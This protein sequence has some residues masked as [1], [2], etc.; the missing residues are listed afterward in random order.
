MELLD[1]YGTKVRELSASLG[2]WP[3]L[4]DIDINN[5][6]IDTL[7]GS[8]GECW[9]LERIEYRTLRAIPPEIERLSNRWSRKLHFVQDWDTALAERAA[10]ENKRMW[11]LVEGHWDEKNDE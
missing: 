4:R 6:A 11:R 2:S 5:T 1:I 9:N 10:E 7:P 3:M 8:L